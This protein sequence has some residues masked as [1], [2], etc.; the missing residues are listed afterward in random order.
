MDTFV[1][2]PATEGKPKKKLLD[3]I[4]DVMRLKH[5]SLRTEQAYTDWIRRLISF[6]NKI[7]PRLRVKASGGPPKAT[8]QVAAATA[9]QSEESASSAVMDR[10]HAA[11][12]RKLE[13]G[14]WSLRLRTL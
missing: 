14:I 5:Y 9:S 1:D 12:G 10:L 3:Q 8:G 11:A 7:I 13:L 4:R 2:T 6:Q